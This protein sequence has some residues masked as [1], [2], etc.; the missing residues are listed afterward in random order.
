MAE[1]IK[2][3]GK[4]KWANGLFDL[5]TLT[6]PDGREDTFWS[7]SFYPDDK[8]LDIV[9]NL[10]SQGVKNNIRRDEDGF[11]INYKRPKVKKMRGEMVEFDPPYVTGPDG[12]KWDR[13]EQINQMAEAE[14]DLA[15]YSHQIPGSTKKAK[16]VRLEGVQ[17]LNNSLVNSDGVDQPEEG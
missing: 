5:K 17:V 11:N 10:Q 1:R 3:K 13:S 14:V 6:A 7:V 16:A 2:V 15:V 8:G 9:Y 12:S 4:I